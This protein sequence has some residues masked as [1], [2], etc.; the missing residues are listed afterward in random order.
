M[1]ISRNTYK[2]IH[3]LQQ[4]RQCTYNGTLLRVRATIVTVVSV[5][6][7]K[8]H[9]K[10]MRLI[11]L[12]SVACPALQYFYNGLSNGTVFEKKLFNTQCVLWFLAGI[13]CQ[14]QHVEY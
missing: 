2:C 10:R 7:S 5:A 11:I 1:N 12:S 13:Y 14:T 8:Q 3:N 9:A 6:L 4:H